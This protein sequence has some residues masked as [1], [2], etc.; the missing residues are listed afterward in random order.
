M[1]S[2][3]SRQT[4]SAP[5][6]APTGARHDL[7]LEIAL[8]RCQ[9]QPLPPIEPDTPSRP[10]ISHVTMGLRCDTEAR[11]LGNAGSPGHGGGGS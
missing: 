9:A 2:I 8:K 10:R 4:T 7:P 6:Q 11:Q 3:T 5:V 1:H